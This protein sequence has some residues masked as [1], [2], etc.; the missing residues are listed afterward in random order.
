MTHDWESRARHAD[1]YDP[2]EVKVRIPVRL[3]LKLHTIKVLTG[4]PISDCVTEALEAYFT[5]DPQ[6]TLDP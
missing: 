5:A 1:E 2:R 4:K 3:H 6:P